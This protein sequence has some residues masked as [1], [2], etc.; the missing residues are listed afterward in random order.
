MYMFLIKS[1]INT[2]LPEYIC[3]FSLRFPNT[4]SLSSKIETL[5]FRTVVISLQEVL[6][7]KVS[8]MFSV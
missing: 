8:P 1:K 2:F 7:L 6:E 5:S 3:V 4:S